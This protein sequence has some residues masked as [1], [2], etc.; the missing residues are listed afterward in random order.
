MEPFHTVSRSFKVRQAAAS[1]IEQV[2]KWGTLEKGKDFNV[3]KKHRVFEK[4]IGLA[5]G[6]AYDQW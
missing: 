4:R 5:K 1:R 6:E 3:K 2:S